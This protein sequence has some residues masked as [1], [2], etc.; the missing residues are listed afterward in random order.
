MLQTG[1]YLYVIFFCHLSIEKA[2]KAVISETSS[3]MPPR[4]HDLLF[5]VGL[6]GMTPTESHLDFIGVLNNAHIATRYPSDLRQA[7]RQYPRKIAG[8]YLKTTVEV[9]KW[10]TSHPSFKK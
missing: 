1:H 4:S 2:L 7:R 3:Q 9:I 5:L 8:E 6:S 10:I